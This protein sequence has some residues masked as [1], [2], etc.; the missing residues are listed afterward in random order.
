MNIEAAR[1]ISEEARILLTSLRNGPPFIANGPLAQNLLNLRTAI[2]Q[3]LTTTVTNKPIESYALPFLNVIL[4]PRAAGPHTLVAVRCI[5]R[6]LSRQS[7]LL[8]HGAQPKNVGIFIDITCLLRNILDCRFEQTDE[9]N[10]EA[11]EMAIADVLSLIVSLLH[12]QEPMPCS[13]ELSH[14]EPELLMEAFNTVFVTR[15]TFVHSPALCYHFEQ[16]LYSFIQD[17]FGHVHENPSCATVC[18]LIFHF[19][20]SQLLHTPM[21]VLLHESKVGLDKGVN[22]ANVGSGRTTRNGTASTTSSTSATA[23]AFNAG[24]GSDVAFYMHG[25]TRILCLGLIQS[26][27]RYLFSHK[28]EEE[29]ENNNNHPK[30]LSQHELSLHQTPFGQIQ[31]DQDRME[32]L[33]L[34]QDDL[35]L[36]LL[37]I[38]QGIW[39][40]QDPSSGAVPG[41]IS[42]QVLSEV[43][44]TISTLWNLQV[45]RPMLV[46]QFESIFTGFYQR[47]LGLLRR[48]PV[49]S[50]SETFHANQ[51]FDME[52]EIILESLVDILCLND[53]STS[54]SHEKTAPSSTFETLFFMYDCNFSRSDV[55]SGLIVEMTRCCG[56]AMDEEGHTFQ[57]DPVAGMSRDTSSVGN[58]SG[59]STPQGSFSR[60]SFDNNNS[61]D[62]DVIELRPVPAHLRELCATILIGAINSLFIGMIESI[63]SP[64]DNSDITT[65]RKIKEK[66]RLMREATRRFNDKASDGIRFLIG[67]GILSE[68]P[69][70]KEVALF[71]RNGITFGLDKQAIGEYLGSIGKSSTAS[72]VRYSRIVHVC[73]NSTLPLLNIR[74][75]K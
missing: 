11:V 13:Q 43:C 72:K 51:I 39:A 34:I 67:H 55:A 47:A 37:M 21:D 29:K 30:E 70:P 14:I 33:D 7:L 36:S 46:T 8:S 57:L 60:L 22:S 15:N 74:H 53:Q 26:C 6:M 9:G 63:A 69:S 31:M 45:L 62:P 35:C 40:Y 23:A 66:K 68:R 48:L 44:N 16:V 19:L 2:S 49:P 18:R 50:D 3:H 73:I 24:G 65:I 28:V 1:H 4:D 25:A 54:L 12:K 10:D 61:F 20:V 75:L 27:L 52:V 38:G 71:L 58:R 32:L 56:G 59:L 17:F 5:Y 64:N 41:M 42:T